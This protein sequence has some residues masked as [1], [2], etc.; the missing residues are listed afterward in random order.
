MP[1]KKKKK[2]GK[3][4]KKKAAKLKVAAEKEEVKG[5]CKIFL[6]A[7]QNNCA[8]SDSLPAPRIISACRECIEEEK[9]LHKVGK[10]IFLTPLIKLF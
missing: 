8:T 3:G 7:Y 5:K 1:A 6:R 4:K 2:G 9:P 10:K